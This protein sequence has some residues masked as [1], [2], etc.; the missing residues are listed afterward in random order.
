MVVFRLPPTARPRAGRVWPS[1]PA[2][3]RVKQLQVYRWNPDNGGNPRLD[4]FPIDLDQCGAMVLDALIKIKTEVDPTLTFGRSCREGICG[5][6]AMSIN[7]RNWLAC[8]QPIADLDG[9]VSIR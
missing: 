2:G 1:P 7:G 3:S 4:V 8:L 9:D 6:C 5:S